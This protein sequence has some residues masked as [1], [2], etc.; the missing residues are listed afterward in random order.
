M[1]VHFFHVQV[2]VLSS[3]FKRIR[4]GQCRFVESSPSL[5]WKNPC[6]LEEK[7]THP[8]CFQ[9]T[10]QNLKQFPS[11][12]GTVKNM[13][14]AWLSEVRVTSSFQP[15][16]NSHGLYSPFV[17][18]VETTLWPKT[19]TVRFFYKSSWTNKTRLSFPMIEIVEILQIHWATWSTCNECFRVFW[20]L[21][22]QNI[23]G[24]YFLIYRSWSFINIFDP[25]AVG[26]STR[27]TTIFSE[28]NK[29]VLIWGL[30]WE[31]K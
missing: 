31:L 28:K 26:S 30:K 14:R 27:I 4:I 24:T 11:G 1:Y 6:G 18:F 10:I 15:K 22:G 12:N 13:K 19:E 2:P 8:R 25:I 17:E 23:F 9:W 21:K 16:L 29:M 20:P 7:K 3:H 5:R